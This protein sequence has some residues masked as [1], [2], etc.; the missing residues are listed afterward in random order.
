MT[1]GLDFQSDSN[2]D[3]LP[4][5][6]PSLLPDELNSTIFGLHCRYVASSMSIF[7]QSCVC[8]MIGHLCP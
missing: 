4:A 8:S 7:G 1:G 2:F 5:F 6:P 3:D